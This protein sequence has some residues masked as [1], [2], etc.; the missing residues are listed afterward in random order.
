MNK[1]HL[2]KEV[3]QFKLF[4]EDFISLKQKRDVNFNSIYFITLLN[5]S[6]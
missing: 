2:M 4:D 6:P 3:H 5:I 1:I